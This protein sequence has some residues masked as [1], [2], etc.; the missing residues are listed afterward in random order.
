[1]VVPGDYGNR[2]SCWV[3]GA[4]F[5]WG[6]I[7]Q[8]SVV[9]LVNVILFFQLFRVISSVPVKKMSTDQSLQ[10][11]VVKR[12]VRVSLSF[13]PV[14]GLTWVFG[15]LAIVPDTSLGFQYLFII[16]NCFQ[17][18]FFF[19][20]HFWHDDK[21]RK[22]WFKSQLVVSSSKSK[23]K[24]NI[25]SLQGHSLLPSRHSL[26]FISMDTYS[27]SG[28][29]NELLGKILHTGNLSVTSSSNE[30]NSTDVSTYDS[31]ANTNDPVLE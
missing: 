25:S 31:G 9:I 21:V 23:R 28:L 7:A 8:L 12:A 18:V 4:V 22:L 13:L 26:P 14:M 16:F 20:F 1:M 29:P 6:F 27:L 30:V 11:A 2:F 17:G 19:K 10:L 15:L 24:S 5:W 3:S